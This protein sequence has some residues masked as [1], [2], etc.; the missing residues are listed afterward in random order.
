MKTKITLPSKKPIAVLVLVAGI[1]LAKPAFA[2]SKPF[3]DLSAISKNDKF[4]AKRTKS[5]TKLFASKNNGAIKIYPDFIKREMHVVAK[6]NNKENVDFYIFDQEGT[7][8]KHY[9]MKPND[10]LCLKDFKRGKYIFRVFSDEEETAGGDRRYRGRGA[11]ARCFLVR[12]KGRC[13]G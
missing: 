13:A 2:D 12:S 4:S 9:K 3:I 5:K 6:D 8:V 11:S 7:L 10:H 1:V